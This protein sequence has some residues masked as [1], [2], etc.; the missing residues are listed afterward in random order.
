MEPKKTKP[1]G[2]LT[3]IYTQA[4]ENS[5]FGQ[6][7]EKDAKAAFKKA[8][9]VGGGINFDAIG[10]AV[11]PFHDPKRLKKLTLYN[12]LSIEEQRFVEDG[13]QDF[14]TDIVNS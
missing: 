14:L 13:Y 10:Q 6:S 11:Q 2:D 12:Q 3:A 5:V 4:L 8:V 7:P 9:M 1:Q